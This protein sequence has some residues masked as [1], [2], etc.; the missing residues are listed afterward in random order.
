MG[1]QATF[2]KDTNTKKECS[3]Y[4]RDDAFLQASNVLDD[5]SPSVKEDSF[6][7]YFEDLDSNIQ[8]VIIDL[9]VSIIENKTE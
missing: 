4:N 8:A 6:M 1:Q 7:V 2:R 3:L 9:I 5:R